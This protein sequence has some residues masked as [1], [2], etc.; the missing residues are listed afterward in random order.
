[1]RFGFYI[2]TLSLFTLLFGS[3]RKDRK[4]NP[5]DR[6]IGSQYMPIKEGMY[7]IYEVN[8][9]IFDAFNNKSDTSSLIIKEIQDSFFTDNIGNKAI[10]YYRLTRDANATEWEEERAYYHVLR[11]TH[12]ESVI[13]NQRYIR[14]TLPVI[15]E[16]VWDINTYNNSSQYLLFYSQLIENYTNGTINGGKSVEITRLGRDLPFEENFFKEVYSANIG[17]VS[18]EFTSIETINNRLEG[19]KEKFELIE[20]GIE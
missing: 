15:K 1:M 6:E 16:S 7:H 13:E 19:I 11:N 14:L 10:R 5:E 3:C 4:Q 12:I 9:I 20:Y 8:R 18:R 2:L 17:M